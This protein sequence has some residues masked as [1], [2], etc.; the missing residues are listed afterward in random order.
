MQYR[1]DVGDPLLLPLI[2]YLLYPHVFKD[3]HHQQAEDKPV[4][5]SAVTEDKDKEADEEGIEDEIKPQMIAPKEHSLIDVLKELK[6]DPNHA[7]SGL[8]V[9][10]GMS[11]V[12]GL[13]QMIAERSGW[14]IIPCNYPVDAAWR[15]GQLVAGLKEVALG[16]CWMSLPNWQARGLRELREK[17]PFTF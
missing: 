14:D 2:A 15:G 5:A 9:V 11:S 16:Q 3:S 17:T 8:L 13:L 4:V 12:S 10:G 6:K 7:K 1:A